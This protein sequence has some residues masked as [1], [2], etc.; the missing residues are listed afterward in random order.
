ML[1]PRRLFVFL[2][3]SP[4]GARDPRRVTW[5][6]FHS[7]V[8]KRKC[9]LMPSLA[10]TSLQSPSRSSESRGRFDFAADFPVASVSFA[11]RSITFRGSPIIF[12]KPLRP[13]FYNRDW[14]GVR[15]GLLSFC[16]RYLEL[17]PHANPLRAIWQHV[18]RPKCVYAESTGNTG[19][20]SSFLLHPC[21]TSMEFLKSSVA[22]P[23][24]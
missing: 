5:P 7:P 15:N 24:P 16:G 3:Q 18:K 13:T 12:G 22:G 10:V 9:L 14:A 4:Q 19:S 21:T 8:E 20:K 1:H 17:T 2:P 11:I 6:L 23:T